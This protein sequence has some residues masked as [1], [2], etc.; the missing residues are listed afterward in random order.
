MKILDGKAVSL[1]IKEKIKRNIDNN[2]L[3]KNKQAPTLACVIVGENPASKVYVGSKKKA[4]DFVGFNSIIIELPENVDY[5]EIYNTITMLNNDENVS[6]ILLQLPLPDNLKIFEKDII[7]LID[8]KKDVDGLTSANLGLL[9]NGNKII[10][11]CTASGLIDLLDYYD[12]DLDGKN[13]VVIGRSLLV[14]KSVAVL[15]E[16]KNAT[17][18]LCH[19]HTKNL[20]EITSKADVLIVAMGKP[21]AITSDM[22]KNG[23]I[24]VD[25]GINR[26]DGK[27]VGDVDFENVSAKCKYITP[28]PGGVGPMTIAE[29]LKNTLKLHELQQNNKQEYTT[30]K[31]EIE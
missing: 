11:P 19:S 24:V 12:I 20:N 22:V 16:Q 8:P 17:V 14:G 10:A 7:E 21:N 9:F 13:A 26:V 23:A 2:Y 30:K 31:R 3:L 4:C 25:V 15:L 29:L 6:G 1:D 27:I 28:V 18:T 5:E